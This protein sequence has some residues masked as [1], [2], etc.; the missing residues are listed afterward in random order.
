MFGLYV[1]FNIM[2]PDDD[3]QKSYTARMLRRVYLDASMS[4]NPVDFME[5]AK[6]P[7]VVAEK[8]GQVSSAG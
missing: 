7:F 1:L 6:T 5:T 8:M 4:L 2:F 3:D